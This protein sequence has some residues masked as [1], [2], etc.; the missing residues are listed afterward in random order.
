MT[1]AVDII[2][3]RGLNNEMYHEL[4]LKKSKA[5]LYLLLQFK[6]VGMPCGWETKLGYSVTVRISAQNN[7]KFYH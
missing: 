2:D 5:T 7:F 3:G 4:L 6:K 1:L